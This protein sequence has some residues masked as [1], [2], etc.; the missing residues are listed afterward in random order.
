MNSRGCKI[1][2]LKFVWRQN[3]LTQLPL[4]LLV[5][6]FGVLWALCAQGRLNSQTDLQS[7][8]R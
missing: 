6:M 1:V 2:S 3:D 8:Q 4:T 7:W 5:L